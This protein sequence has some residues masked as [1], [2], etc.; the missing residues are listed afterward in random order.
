ME[1][2]GIYI[3]IPLTALTATHPFTTVSPYEA[4]EGG[5]ARPT[6]ETPGAQRVSTAAEDQGL[7]REAPTRWL[8][9]DDGIFEKPTIY[10]YISI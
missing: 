9:P 6:A 4:R 8:E 1:G 10:R 3:Y 2:R 7:P 5:Q